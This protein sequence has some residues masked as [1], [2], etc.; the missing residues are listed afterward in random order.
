MPKG[1]HRFVAKPYSRNNASCKEYVSNVSNHI[2]PLSQNIPF[3]YLSCILSHLKIRQR[4]F[5]FFL[6]GEKKER[7]GKEIRE[8]IA[9]YL[10]KEQA[11]P[12]RH[13]HNVWVRPGS[14]P[15]SD[16]RPGR[17]KAEVCAGGE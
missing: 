4:I 9:E 3:L 10:W 14:Y 8:K 6:G 15:G 2:Y 5:D 7:E 13:W 17:G 1:I 12:F 11:A 16:R